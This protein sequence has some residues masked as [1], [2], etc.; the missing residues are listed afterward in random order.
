MKNI[1]KRELLEIWELK[2]RIDQLLHLV[3][4]GETV[5]IID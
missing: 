2:E 5:K 4:N 3:E 1:E